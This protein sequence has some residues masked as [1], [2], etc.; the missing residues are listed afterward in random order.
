MKTLNLFVATTLILLGVVCL[1]RGSGGTTITAA[2]QDKWALWQDGPH[3]RGANIYQRRSY[4]DADGSLANVGPIIPPYVQ[5]DFDKMAA[6]GANYVNISHPGLYTETPPY[7]VDPVIEAN[8]DNL[9][10]MIANANMVAVISFRTGPGRNE[11]IFLEEENALWLG[12]SKDI[13]VMWPDPNNASM[14]DEQ[15]AQAAQDGWV[16]MWQY[17]AD[18][19][20]DNPIVVGYDLMVE[21]NSNVLLDI[22]DPADFYPA[23]A[24]TLY[25]WNQLYPEITTAIRQVDTGTPILI[26]AMSYSSIVWLPYLQPTADP[27]TIYTIHQ[28]EPFNYTHQDPPLTLAYPGTF[29]ADGDGHDD[30]VNQAWLDNWLSPIDDFK[31]THHVPVAVNEYGLKRWQP[32]AAQ[33][34]ADLMALFEQRGLNHAWWLWSPADPRFVDYTHEFNPLLGP[35]PDNRDEVTTSALLQT[36]RRNWALNSANPQMTGTYLPIIL[37]QP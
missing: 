1:S 2:D 3:L 12:Y 34:M 15:Q 25:D 29:D 36:I 28:Y 13:N 7:Q 14:L 6:L 31:D 37:V 18:R 8:L 27:H 30:T 22:W 26:G 19:Y 16:A 4:P 5:D 20:R 33:F 11:F 23:R 21:P 9:L 17:T 24:G 35:D 32:G 10:V